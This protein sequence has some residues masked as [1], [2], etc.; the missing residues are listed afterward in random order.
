MFQRHRTILSRS[1]DTKCIE[2]SA[3]ACRLKLP[4]LWYSSLVIAGRWNGW[5]EL[6]RLLEVERWVIT[7]DSS[8]NKARR[9]ILAMSVEK[10][11]SPICCLV[12]GL[13][14]TT[15]VT[16][17]L[18]AGDL[19][20]F[21]VSFQSSRKN[22]SINLYV[23]ENLS[24]SCLKSLS[25]SLSA[26]KSWRNLNSHLLTSLRLRL[27]YSPFCSKHWLMDVEVNLVKN[28][29]IMQFTIPGWSARTWTVKIVF[30]VIFYCN[31]LHDWD[32]L[33]WEY[34]GKSKTA[35]AAKLAESTSR[36]SN[37]PG[38]RSR[39]KKK[40]RVKSSWIRSRSHVC[41]VFWCN[42]HAVATFAAVKES[43]STYEKSVDL[44]MKQ[45]LFFSANVIANTLHTPA[46]EARSITK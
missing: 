25:P 31:K 7:H 23:L 29:K 27:L 1:F 3:A 45:L 19:V 22:H 42:T 44:K 33:W 21:S 36:A 2:R 16:S 35:V 6:Q 20:K 11:T 39:G 4:I 32:V 43:L 17:K 8:V 24:A 34:C 37:L 40:E 41:A 18:S 5:F 15:C 9:H 30:V 38:R 12:F 10:R 26:C 28:W 14:C 13:A 46:A